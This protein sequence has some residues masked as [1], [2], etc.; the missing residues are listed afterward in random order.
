MLIAW[1]L[2]K[3]GSESIDEPECYGAAKTTIRHSAVREATI[4]VEPA[5]PWCLH[6]PRL[7]PRVARCAVNERSTASQ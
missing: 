3:R 7:G 6:A 5:N 2:E 1:H 4:H